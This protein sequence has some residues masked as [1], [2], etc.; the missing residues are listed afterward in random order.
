MASVGLAAAD[1]AKET[2]R[3]E[4][5]SDG[6]FAIAV[7]LLILEIRAPAQHDI[8][9]DGALWHALRGLWPAYLAYIISFATILVTWINHHAIMRLVAR[10]DHA[11]LLLN[12]LLLALITAVNFPTSLIAEYIGHPGEQAAALAYSGVFLLMAF[13]FNILWRYTI[14]HD[15]LLLASADRAQ[16]RAI[17][18]RFRFGPLYYVAAFAVAF[19]NAKASLIFCL[20]L[21]VLFALPYTDRAAQPD[22]RVRVNT[23]RA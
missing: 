2:G 3:A 19:V 4:A 15:R 23:D 16:V 17:D 22:R 10:T 6:I 8:G 21:A 20:L 7:T 12:G 14:W 9:S 18:R 1:E 5:F 11:F 13:A